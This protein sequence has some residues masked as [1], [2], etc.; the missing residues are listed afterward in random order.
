MW[1]RKKVGV[2]VV[3]FLIFVAVQIGRGKILL[4]D[5]AMILSSIEEHSPACFMRDHDL[6]QKL[7]LVR[8]WAQNEMAL[9][10]GMGGWKIPMKYINSLLGPY[11]IRVFFDD[12]VIGEN[13][14]L[15]AFEWEYDP[16]SSKKIT[17]FFR[18]CNI[19]KDSKSSENFERLLATLG[20]NGVEEITFDM[21][22]NRGGNSNYGNAIVESIFGK[23]AIDWLIAN[24][25]RA[26]HYRL[27]AENLK[28]FAVN[29]EP[30]IEK[31]RMDFNSGRHM[32][33]EFPK[34]ERGDLF[35]RR[36]N[37]P[38]IRVLMDD[39]LFSAAADFVAM[40]Q[41]LDEN[42]EIIGPRGIFEYSYGDIDSRRLPSNRGF[43]I[44]PMKYSEM[45]NDVPVRIVPT[46][47]K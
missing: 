30:N 24:Y 40:L 13:K 6:Q 27:T 41:L 4:E 11:H 19:G 17:V 15:P 12:E 35:L 3:A 31:L 22:G 47:S 8:T 26:T 5:I 39:K 46:H 32:H 43:F 16:P 14:Q 9:S 2:S 38:H 23:Y 18:S 10:M 45:R 36:K 29:G 7:A 21:R 44:F 37:I 25:F 28:R 20:S 33:V 1:T 34:A 42:I